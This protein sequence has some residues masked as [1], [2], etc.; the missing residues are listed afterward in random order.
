MYRK[1][2]SLT[3]RFNLAF[4]F[5]LISHVPLQFP[6]SRS[7]SLESVGC[8]TSISFF[9]YSRSRSCERH[10]RSFWHNHE[11]SCRVNASAWRTSFFAGVGWLLVLCCRVTDMR[12]EWGTWIAPKFY[13]ITRLFLFEWYVEGV[14]IIILWVDMA[15]SAFVQHSNIGDAISM[16]FTGDWTPLAHHNGR[17][18]INMPL[19]AWALK[20]IQNE[21][22][23]LA[24]SSA[25]Q[26]KVAPGEEAKP[27]AII[28]LPGSN[29]MKFKICK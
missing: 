9:S 15:T 23:K 8:K 2:T 28:K 26:E 4:W 13:L 17:C 27:S 20:D 3:S 24:R 7:I 6:F 29:F 25:D 12:W 22:V 5:L 1:M 18:A 11:R 19:P 16:F 10:W 14:F 21:Q